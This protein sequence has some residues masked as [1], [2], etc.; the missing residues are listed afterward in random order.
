MGTEPSRRKAFTIAEA[1]FTSTQQRVLGILF[2]HT[3]RSFF[4]TE[5]FTRAK[6]GRGSVQRELEKLSAAGL[7]TITTVGA[8]KHYQANASAPVFEELRSIIRKTVGLSDPIREALR[9]LLKKI[10]VAFVYGSVARGEENAGSDVDLL[11][12]SDELTL[13]SVIKRMIP[14][15]KTLGRTINPTLYTSA[16]YARRDRNAF[17]RK[18]VAGKKIMLVGRDDAE[19]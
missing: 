10:D 12:V 16:E 6:S 5:I 8:Q 4:A 3:D 13:E 15:E 7:V 9:P 11:I 19:G 1:L 14:V 2:G 18:V 17:L